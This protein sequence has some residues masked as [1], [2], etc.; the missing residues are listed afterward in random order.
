MALVFVRV[1]DLEREAVVVSDG[2]VVLVTEREDGTIDEL[3]RRS[4]GDTEHVTLKLGAAC[5][6]LRV[7]LRD[8]AADGGLLLVARILMDGAAV[9]VR[10][11]GRRGDGDDDLPARLRAESKIALGVW[12]SGTVLGVALADL[13]GRKASGEE[14]TGQSL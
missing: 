7:G 6:A 3:W 4:S 8:G 2:V 1:A 14:S 13:G 12:V 11:A 9:G 5:A 10:L